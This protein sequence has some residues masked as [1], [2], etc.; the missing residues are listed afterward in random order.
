M[1]FRILFASPTYNNQ[2]CVPSHKVG[3]EFVDRVRSELGVPD[4]ELARIE[5][6]VEGAYMAPE[7]LISEQTARNSGHFKNNNQVEL[8]VPKGFLN[9]FYRVDLVVQKNSSTGEIESV[10]GGYLPDKEDI[11]AAWAH[12]GYPLR[13]GFDPQ[14]EDE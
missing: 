4:L 14:D 8:E 1:E 11:V 12:D 3:L 13:W 2:V 9:R 7:I 6:W 5:D 10:T